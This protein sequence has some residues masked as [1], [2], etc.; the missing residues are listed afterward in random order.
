VATFVLVPGLTRDGGQTPSLTI[1]RDTDVRFELTLEPG[2][3][4][5]Y[6]VVLQTADGA[7]I[8]RQDGSRIV[9]T[10]SGDAIVVTLP[11][12]RFSDDDYIIRVAGVSPRGEADEVASFYFRT[13]TR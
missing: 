12:A 6:R 5:S 13:M 7:E 3:Y 8:W 1:A 9:R 2:D 10:A 4:D 11:G